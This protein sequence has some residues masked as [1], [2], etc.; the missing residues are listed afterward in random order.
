MHSGSAG[1]AIRAA[2]ITR[3][4]IDTIYQLSVDSAAYRQYSFVYLL[5]QETARYDPDGRSTRT[6][7]QVVQ[8]LKPTAVQTWAERSIAYR[9]E[10]EKLVVNWI[11]VVRPDGEI[12]SDKP[13]QTQESDVPASVRDPVYTHTR[14]LRYSLANVAPGTIVDISTTLEGN[15]PP[16]PGDVLTSW[17]V[18]VAA[19][20]MR[21]YFSLDVPTS[22]RP[23]IV[24][25]HLDFRRAETE[26]GGRHLFVWAA[27]N[28]RP[29]ARELFAPDSSV[30]AMSIRVG[31]PLSWSDIGRWYHGLSHDRYVLTPSLT[32]VVDSVVRTARTADDTIEALHRWIARDLR[33]V[34]VALGTGDYQPR[35][36]EV[37][38]A[39]GFGD[40]KDKATLFIAAARH[41]HIAAY[42]VLLNSAGI[43]DT[44]LPAVEEFDHVI[45]AV[46]RRGVPEFTY[47]DLTTD[48]YS[49][50]HVPPS[51]QGSFGLVVMPDG[52]SRD[53][54]F[55]KDSGGVSEERFV[56]ELL[57]D[58]HV[59]G[60]FFLTARGGNVESALRA[61]YALPPDSA[62][63]ANLKRSAPRPFPGAS[64]DSM[65]LP[66]AA[67]LTVHPTI[68][69]D[70]SAGNGAKAAGPLMILSLPT[71]FQ[72]AS[73]RF[74]SVPDE[75]TRAGPRRLP[76]DA[77]RILGGF[78]TERE[79]RLTLPAGWTAQL[80]A[81]V[82][83]TGPFGS[84]QAEYHQVGRE[85]IVSHTVRGSTGVY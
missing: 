1:A 69:V 77:S 41:F 49:G 24:E 32:G 65:I 30:P 15:T 5:D 76:I 66:D 63:R 35:L 62:R 28:V 58:G 50:G 39:T 42:P 79:L 2:G 12:V 84:F 18:S 43:V 48:E 34:S 21:S 20:A 53:I 14:V 55:P 68:E 44:T 59:N 78:T 75:L 51:Y 6:F 38:V 46:P 22:I 47:L 83:V 4:A 3:P 40:C 37:T 73:Q 33:Y 11:R 7:R 19:P 26:S 64:V 70:L 80:P 23:R 17:N 85:L 54:T 67:N 9:P 8:I 56:G 81:P 29:P 31:A 27:Q 74:R 61:V 25:R 36:P 10:H 60:K 82:S 45:A 16:L 52:T 13:A 71:I 72:G 57:P